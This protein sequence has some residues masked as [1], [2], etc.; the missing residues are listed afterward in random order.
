MSKSIAL[1]GLVGAGAVLLAI[2]LTGCSDTPS[3][4]PS[5][6]AP[7][8]TLAYTPTPTPTNIPTPVPTPTYRRSRRLR[9]RMA[10]TNTPTPEP[11]PTP[12]MAPTNTPTPEPTPTPTPDKHAH[13]GADAY[14]AM[15][16]SLYEYL[17]L[18]APPE[19]ELADDATFGD[20]SSL[21]A[22]EADRLE[23]LTPPAQLSEWHLL[24]IEAYRTVQA[25]VDSQP[26][27]DVIGFANFLTNRG[28]SR[29][30]QKK[31]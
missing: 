20:L 13:A 18:C 17:T 8:G 2:L 24:N 28:R 5:A 3:P 31:S 11:T 1:F 27:D 21:F 25:V 10:P 26:K 19:Q 6:E 30:F 14:P 12:T 4:T 23:A 7:A 15:P 16:L 22:A 9:P 29:R